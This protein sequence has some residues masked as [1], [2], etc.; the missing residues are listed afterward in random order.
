MYLQLYRSKIQFYRKFGGNGRADRFKQFVR[1]AYR[2]RLAIASLLALF[3]ARQGGQAETY[4][5]LL[6]E[7]PSM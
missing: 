1:L 6:A 4:R 5:Q 2:P 7:L 3:S